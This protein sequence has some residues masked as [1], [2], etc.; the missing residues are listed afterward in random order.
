MSAF[1]PFIREVPG[2]IGHNPAL[3]AAVACLVR[4]HS[5]L[6]HKKHTTEIANPE[7]YLRAVQTLQMCL[8]DPLQHASP[9]TL[10]ASVL[11][12]IV[13]VSISNSSSNQA[14]RAEALA[15][16]RAGN[17]YLAHV[18]GAGRLLELQGP[19]RCQDSFAKEI[20]RFNRGGIVSNPLLCPYVKWRRNRV[21]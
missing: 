10:C 19:S 7:L 8:E 21:E 9:N 3:D 15:G 6:V 11:L 17:R 4:A 18:G 1:G 2:R 5:V 14:N 20:L 16:P 13:E 12:G